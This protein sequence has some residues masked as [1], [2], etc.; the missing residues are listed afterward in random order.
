MKTIFS[1][2]IICPQQNSGEG[3]HKPPSLCG[4]AAPRGKPMAGLWAGTGKRIQ[5]QKPKKNTETNETKKRNSAVWQRWAR[6][7]QQKPKNK[8]TILQETSPPDFCVFGFCFFLFFLAFWFC[9][10]QYAI[11]PGGP[12]I[13]YEDE[14]IL[15]QRACFKTMLLYSYMPMCKDHR[16]QQ[17]LWET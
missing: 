14:K 1:R 5:N 17:G 15:K 6:D 11:L 16:T 9:W 7:L 2:T 8:K 13:Q 3:W 10:C 12:Y 4:Q